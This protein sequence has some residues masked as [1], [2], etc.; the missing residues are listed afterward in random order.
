MDLV[1]SIRSQMPLAASTTPTAPERMVSGPA[2]KSVR[3]VTETLRHEAVHQPPGSAAQV[4]V[5]LADRDQG[6]H[7]AAEARATAQAA[8]EAYIKASIAAGL[9]PLPLP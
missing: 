4:A 1:L 5:E 8:R 3:P 7:P 2:A 6:Q 9:S